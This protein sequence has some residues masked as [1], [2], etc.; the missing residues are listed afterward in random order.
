MDKSHNKII[1]AAARE[2]LQP[3]RFSQRGRSRIWL[4][5][6]KWWLTVVEF[7][8]SGLTKGSYLNVA[9]HWLWS[10]SGHLTFD[11]GGRTGDFVEF[12]SDE[13]F[14]P[15]VRQLA[16]IAG[17]K[18]IELSERFPNVE[19]VA[20][21]LITDQRC[22]SDE[23]RDGWQAYNAGMAAG[24]SGRKEDALFMF[25]SIKNPRMKPAV[26]RMARLTDD[27]PA[28]RREAEHLIAAQ[29]RALKLAELSDLAFDNPKT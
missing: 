6:H 27:Q 13:Q 24:I 7:Q 16:K 25:Q 22:L 23:R 26:K 19:A 18:A 21:L 12:V 9:A 20:D 11:W 28:F 1:E 2:V 29:R 15:I 4:A 10:A 14:T 5:D 17:A 3:L 8:P